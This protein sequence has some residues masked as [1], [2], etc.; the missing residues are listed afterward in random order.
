[1][2]HKFALA[3]L[4]TLV[5]G[6]AAVGLWWSAQPHSTDEAISAWRES[7]DP[8]CP[9]TPATQ[10]DLDAAK[11]FG[12]G[13]FDSDEWRMEVSDQPGFIRVNWLLHDGAISVYS[14]Y[15]LLD[16]GY[17]ESD[18]EAF[19][20]PRSATMNG[21]FQDYDGRQARYACL[22]D[23]TGMGYFEL[24]KGD[25]VTFSHVGIEQV[26]GERVRITRTDAPDVDTLARTVA[27]GQML[28]GCVMEFP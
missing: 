9:V 18:F 27:G 25:R 1:M 15:V 2:R 6:A 5:V 3:G 12:E 4:V 26:N 17:T 19:T 23:D 20:E 16:C 10:D 24:H 8:D 13:T 14:Y 21:I 28:R 7:V 11:V 22:P